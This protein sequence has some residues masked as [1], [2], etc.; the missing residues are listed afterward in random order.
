LWIGDYS[1][2]YAIHLYI[3]CWLAGERHPFEL[4]EGAIE[5]RWK[6]NGIN[7]L[8]CGLVLDPEDK[9]WIFFTMNG[10]LRGELVLEVLRI[11]KKILCIFPVINL[12]INLNLIMA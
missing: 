4:P 12:N 8:G 1:N 5:P 2:S 3:E 10:K 11:R 6:R 9:L 7:V